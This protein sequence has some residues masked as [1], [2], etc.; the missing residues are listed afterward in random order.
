M[1]RDEGYGEEMVGTRPERA[2]VTTRN[3]AAALRGVVLLGLV[4][5]GVLAA[6]VSLGTPAWDE[7]LLELAGQY[8]DRGLVDRLDTM[9]AYGLRLAFGIAA[10]AV[11]VMVVRRRWRWAVF[12]IL[13][14]AGTAALDPVLKEAF[15]RPPLGN[16]EG[17]YS[18]P[19]GNA[20]GTA[21]LVLTVV[22]CSPPAWQKLL[23]APGALVVLLGGVGIVY[24]GWH[25]PSDV[26]A[27]WCVGLAWVALVWLA[28]RPRAADARAP[29]GV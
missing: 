1:Q 3:E 23:A 15:R 6:L 7:R 4:L 18:F 8:F 5:F 22:L 16:P 11:V 27:G 25:Y 10:G 12:L 14:L 21:A 17:D 29:S 24:A 26:L 20:L 13:T 19:S 9:L 28:V 2:S